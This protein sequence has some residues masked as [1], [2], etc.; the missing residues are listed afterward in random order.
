LETFNIKRIY[1]IFV[2]VALAAF[3]NIILGIFPPLFSSISSDLGIPIHL[4][5][6][7]L[8]VNIFVTCISALFWSYMAGKHNRKKL[9]ILGT[10]FW[11]VSVFLT[12]RANNF[13]EMLICQVLIGIALGCIT[14][15]GFSVLTDFIPHKNR[16]MVLSLWGSAQGFGGIAG[17]VLA[18]VTATSTSWRKPFEIVSIVG[19]VLVVL[20]FFVKVPA[21]GEAEPE[22]QELIKEGYEYNHTIDLNS[23]HSIVT[24]KSNILL[25]LQA[26]FMNITSST[27]IWLPTL[28]IAKIVSLGYSSKVAIIASGFLFAMFQIGGMSSGI[29]GHLGDMVHK[30][31][32]RARSRLSAFF[33]IAMI[34]FYTLMFVIPMKKLLLPN[35][36][37]PLAILFAL[38]HQIFVNPWLGSIFLFSLFA[39]ALQSANPPNWLA[40]ITDVNL[41][42]NRGAAFSIANLA[43]GVG[44][45][46]GNA[47]FGILLS[48]LTLHL[49]EPTNYVV[50]LIIFQLF[51]I[52]SAFMY[53]RMS[54]YNKKDINHVK[55]TLRKRALHLKENPNPKI[56]IE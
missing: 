29:F 50:T 40:L 55:Y 18:S 2:F 8:A 23:L 11:S 53:I 24:R 47:M 49:K 35:T 25:F 56:P 30:K 19:L 52:P 31:S 36:I 39:S 16:G 14:S 44:R 5:G 41:P 7:I 32:Y 54:K 4:L 10:V 26:F 21:M 13:N 9:I 20:Y 12:S 46:I 28:Y 43:N 17:A 3:D 42:E 37:D 22:L 27:I 51:L 45:A 48:F 15:I 33:I 6:I 38:L 1:T 34:P